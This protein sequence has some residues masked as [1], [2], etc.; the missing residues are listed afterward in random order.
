MHELWGRC[1]KCQEWFQVEDPKLES[2]FLC[3]TCL[4]AAY[5]TQWRAATERRKANG[6]A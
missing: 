1:P 2:Y 3:P 6:V 5:R 4:I